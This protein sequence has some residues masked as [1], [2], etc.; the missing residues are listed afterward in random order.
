ML[1]TIKISIYKEFN[2][3]LYTTL[4]NNSFAKS[5]GFMVN[6]TSGIMEQ[7]EVF[8]FKQNNYDNY[9]MMIINGKM[10]V[11]SWNY[12]IFFRCY[13]DRVNIEFSLP[14][15]IYGT[16]VIQ[17]CSHVSKVFDPYDM[18]VL[19]VKKFFETFFFGHAID[20]GGIK[21]LRWDF[22][23][24]Q[25]YNTYENSIK[26]LNYIK[27]KHS[28]KTDTKNY[29]FGYIELT[30]NNYLKIYH[31]GEEFRRHDFYKLENNVEEFVNMS[32]K[33]L[34]YER[35]YTPSNVAYNYNVKVKYVNQPF[36]VK[37]YL[38]RKKSGNITKQMRSDFENVQQFT[39]GS[40]KIYGATKLPKTFFNNLFTSFKNE[41][42]KKFSINGSSIDRL[43]HEVFD[44]SDKTN[45]AMKI[46]ILALIKTFKSL[47]KAYEKT[48]ISKSTY[49]RYLSFMDK[50]NLS[51]TNIPLTIEQDFTNDSYFRELNKNS[52]V[53]NNLTKNIFF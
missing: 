30:K 40:S 51:T 4:L 49:Y 6:S 19:S 48:A 22:C 29:E 2:N 45:K 27:L 50:K 35:K 33:I 3:S 31:K 46:K 47:K 5:S 28:S 8:R 38:L 7:K 16:N 14:K 43:K 34:R 24:N 53:V 10:N 32:S 37:E 1:D 52:I 42:I 11:P 18:L 25:V 39:L 17:L 13:D 26:A 12:D 23:F 41:I 9:Q 36:L 15:F 20:Y 21:L 44:T